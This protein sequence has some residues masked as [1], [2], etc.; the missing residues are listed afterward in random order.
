[1]GGRDLLVQ[2]LGEHVDA[3]LV[4]ARVAPQIDLGKDLLEKR[5]DNITS[6]SLKPL[7]V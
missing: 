5:E 7:H 4:L 2:L 3:D 1:M 6:L